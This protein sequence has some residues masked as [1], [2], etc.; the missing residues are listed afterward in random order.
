MAQTIVGLNS[1]MAV[2]IY[3]GNLAVDIGRKG[4][5]T[6]KFMGSGEVPTKP[7]WRLTNLE[8]DSGEQITYDLS[9]QLKA[10]PTQGDN[11]VEGKEEALNFYTDVVYID[12]LRHGVDCGGRMTRKRTLHD[13]RK[14]G[15]ARQV[16]YWARLFDETFFMYLSGSRG[17]NSEFIESPTFSGYANNAFTAPDTQHIV[18]GGVAQSAQTMAT[19]DKM[20]LVAIDRFVAYAEMMGGGTQGIPQIQPADVDGEKRYLVVMDPNQAF[21]LRNGTDTNGWAE[22]Q[23]ALATAVGNKSAFITGAIG[24][25]NDVV[26]HKHQNCIR[27]TNYGANGNVSATRA[28]GCGIQAAT[29]AFGSPGKDLR[30]GWREEEKDA[31]NRIAIYTNTIV[32]IKKVTFNGLDFGVMAIDTAAKR[33]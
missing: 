30:F 6:N 17:T 16:D 24:I 7:I 21:D 14:I 1:P 12:Q 31:G 22:I 5:W 11:I 9:M 33:P 8:A 13:L 4:Y 23:K 3:S 19:T 27:F 2:K 32:G 18:Y 29:I 26:M 10:A 25:H 20:S 15:K 28:L